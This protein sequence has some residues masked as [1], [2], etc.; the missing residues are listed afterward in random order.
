MGDAYDGHGHGI[1]SH[2]QQGFLPGQEAWTAIFSALG[3]T[4]YADPKGLYPNWNGQDDRMLTKSTALTLLDEIETVDVALFPISHAF[5]TLCLTWRCC[6][7]TN[8]FEQRP[9][10][11]LNSINF[12]PPARSLLMPKSLQVLFRRNDYLVNYTLY[13]ALYIIQSVNREAVTKRSW[14][15]MM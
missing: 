2:C 3:L 4:I 12:D 7:W 14:L 11:V 8:G 1:L 10:L 9:I 5:T 6:C 15:E 13:I